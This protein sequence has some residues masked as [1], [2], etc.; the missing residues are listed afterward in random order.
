MKSYRWLTLSLASLFCMIPLS[1]RVQGEE[2]RFTLD[3]LPYSAHA[4]FYAAQE[5]GVYRENGLSVKIER[6]IGSGDTVKKVAGGGSEYGFA[7]AG[8]LVVAL[9]QGAKAKMLAVLF[10]KSMYTIL[11]LKGNG[12]AKPKDLEGRRLGSP[13]GAAPRVLF[14]AFAA[15][16]GVDAARVEMVNVTPAAAI[17]SLL[18]GKVDAIGLFTISGAILKMKAKAEGKEVTEILYSDYGIDIYSN[19]IVASAGRVEKE[20]D[21]VRRF[22][23]GSVKGAAWAVEHPEEALAVFLKAHPSA[24]KILARA[25]FKIAVDHLLTP[26]AMKEGICHM[27]EEKAG[28]TI[29]TVL[30]Y[31]GLKAQIRP[32]DF[33]TNQFLPRI[34]VKRPESL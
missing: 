13:I 26:T 33:Y 34:I 32:S 27:T 25:Q 18:A 6:G 3:W 21:Q 1:S 4:G 16:S 2:V 10:D 17:P 19:G 28:T 5:R 7:D 31:Y 14:P 22:V 12:I 29:Q 23:Q 9:A 20:Q 11:S 8:A 15:A 24:D 30:K